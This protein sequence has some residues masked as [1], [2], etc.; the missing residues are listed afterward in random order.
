MVA[1]GDG[2][3]VEVLVFQGLAD[4]LEALGRITAPCLD[5]LDAVGKG[6]VVGID[7]VRDLH[8]LQLR[9]AA[10]MVAAAAV[11]PGHAD[12]DRL[13]G[14]E[15]LVLAV[16]D[17]QSGGDSA[18]GHGGQRG[19]PLEETASSLSGHGVLLEVGVGGRGSGGGG[20]GPAVNNS[21]W[22]G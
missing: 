19:R 12:A 21:L 2:D 13:V 6:A 9:I 14:S 15:D 17:R 8:V 11:N 4:V 16:G 3:R 5:L 10:N 1:G 22:Y 7:E 18:A 20:Q